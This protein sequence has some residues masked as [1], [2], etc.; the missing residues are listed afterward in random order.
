LA[1]IPLSVLPKEITGVEITLSNLYNSKRYCVETFRKIMEFNDNGEWLG[2]KIELKNQAIKSA[3]ALVPDLIEAHDAIYSKFPEWYNQEG[4][5]FGKIQGVRLYNPKGALE[6]RKK[7]SKNKFQTKFLGA[8][9]DYWYGEGFILPL[10]VGLRNLI[11]TS[12]RSKELNWEIDPVEFMDSQHAEIM[13]LYASTLRQ[14]NL[15]PQIIGKDKGSYKFADK[16]I[17][18]CLTIMSAQAA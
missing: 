1:L 6:D 15:N 9:C 17:K 11:Q 2:Q 18:M 3:L 10:V 16:A 5:S 7:Y 8:E 4:G 14:G 13:D 12:P